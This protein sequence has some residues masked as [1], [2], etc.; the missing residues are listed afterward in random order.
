MTNDKC[1]ILD[2]TAGKLL[3]YDSEFHK[4]HYRLIDFMDEEVELQVNRES[5]MIMAAE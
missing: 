4:Y 2:H 3:M 1:I 5:F